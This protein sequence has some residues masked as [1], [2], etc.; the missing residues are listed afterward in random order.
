MFNR[1]AFSNYVKEETGLTVTQLR[2][3]LTKQGVPLN[4]I[5]NIY[6]KG[7]RDDFLKKEKYKLES[8]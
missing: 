8:K 7:M 4:D 2:K 6:I 5:D 3:E 1:R